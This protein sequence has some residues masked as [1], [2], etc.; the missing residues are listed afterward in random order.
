M[1]V[2]FYGTR[3]SIPTPMGQDAVRGKIRDVL[4]QAHG[5]DLSSGEAVDRFIDDNLGFH[6]RATFG[7]DTSCVQIDPEDGTRLICDAGSGLRRFGN[8]MLDFHGA[9]APQEYHILM[10][11]LH[12]DHMMGFPFFMPAYIPGNK[13]HIHSCHNVVEEAF[14]NQ[15]SLPGF[16]VSFDHMEAEITFHL[17]EPG[18]PFEVAGFTVDSQ[19]Q[20]HGGRSYGYRLNGYGKTIVYSTDSEHKALSISPDYPFVHFFRDADLL[21]FDAQYS[22]VESISIKEDWGHSSNI[23]GVELARMAKAKRLCLFHHEPNFDDH[24]LSKILQDTINYEQLSD[25]MPDAHRVEILS[26][27]DGLE[28]V[29]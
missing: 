29:V 12:W 26:A 5:A 25:E 23:I 28:V 16:P 8:D 6:H 7:G 11:H 27:Y 14:R 18:T 3:G 1:K 21:I 19:A 2:R 4:L 9:D 22:L 17:H 13:V 24:T 10:S 15:N 20:N